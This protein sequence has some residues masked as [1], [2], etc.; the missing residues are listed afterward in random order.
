MLTPSLLG[1]QFDDFV[2]FLETEIQ[3]DAYEQTVQKLER[4]LRIMTSNMSGIA[5]SLVN[6]PNCDAFRKLLP[7]IE[8][9][10][11]IMDKFVIYMDPHGRFRIRV[12][13]FKTQTENLGATPTIHD[14]R[15]HYTTAILTGSY[16]EEIFAVAPANSEGLE[17]AT[18][19]KTREMK[20]GS[21]AS[22]SPRTPHRTINTDPMEQCISFFVRGRSMHTQ[23]RVYDYERFQFRY[24]SG[25]SEQIASELRE[26][27]AKIL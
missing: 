22:L 27:A 23:S 15:W 19:V 4:E 12:H 8:Y 3:W 21:V 5:D 16:R 10:R 9:P 25:R 20:S 2:R 13:R 17:I 1:R 6:L 14:H 7:H 26:I 18:V 11:P 24:L